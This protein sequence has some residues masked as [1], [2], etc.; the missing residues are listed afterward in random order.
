MLL[1]T[2]AIRLLGEGDRGGGPTYPARRLS[3]SI[4]GYTILYVVKIA[5]NEGPALL[6]KA[7]RDERMAASGFTVLVEITVP[8]PGVHFRPRWSRIHVSILRDQP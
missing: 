2:N 1:I 4:P 5:L 7:I 3:K 6:D 8:A